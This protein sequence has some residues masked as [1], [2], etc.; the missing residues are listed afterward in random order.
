MS[1]K[2]HR[3]NYSSTN[4]LFDI[5]TGHVKIVLN[6]HKSEVNSIFPVLFPSNTQFR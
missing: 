4:K 2:Y 1:L 3:S 6:E 5:A